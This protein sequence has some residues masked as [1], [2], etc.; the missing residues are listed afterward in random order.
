MATN[1]LGRLTLDLL[2]SMGSFEQGMNAAERKAKQSAQ[3]MTNSFKGFNDQ[4][5]QMI[6]GTQLGSVIDSISTKL[7]AMRGGI[8]VVTS[9]LAGM[10]VGGTLLAVG[11]LSVM[12]VQLAKNNIELANFAAVANTSVE[13]FQGLAGAA[14]S[15]GITQ[16]KLSDQLK[17]FNEKIGE[18][19]SVGSGGAKDFFE[20][21]AVQTE[22]GAAG[23]KKLAEEMSKKDGVDALQIYV[24]KLQEAGV[25]QQQ[26]SFYL[27]SMGSDLTV[28]APLL[29]NG[30]ALWK[31][32]QAAMEDAGIITGQEAIEKSIEL[33][34]QTE[35]VQMQF[36]ALKNQLAQA[37]M[38]AL[39]SVIGYF[40]EGSG[41]GGQFSG[42]IEGVGYAAK[43][44]AV[45]VVGLSAGVK[46][47]VQVIS[48]ALQLIGNLGQTVIEFW[49]APSFLGKGRAL[50]DGFNRNGNILVET[51]KGVKNSVVDGYKTISNVVSGQSGKFDAL[52]QS[53]INNKKAQMEWAKQ[54]GKGVVSGI[55][56]NKALNPT[57]KVPKVKSAK[58]QVDKAKREQEALERAQQSIV[59]QY[60]DD[61]L[62]LKLRYEADKEKIVEAFAKDP[63]N[64]DLYL[65]KAKQ[66]Y[67]LDVA[68]YKQAQ[69][70]KFAS[71]HNDFLSKMADAEDAISISNIAKRYGAKS[72]QHG[73]AQLN[74]SSRKSKESEL[75][76]YTN[77]VN[78]INRDYDTPDK[79]VQRYELLEQAKAAHIAKMKALDVEYHD[80]AKQLVLDNKL[81]QLNAW[82]SILDGAQ[83]TFAQ[84]TQSAKE[85]AGEQS[86]VY[87]AMFA[88]QQA[89]SIASSMVAAYS[90]YAQAFADPS[91]MT[92]PQK[93]AGGAAVMA[94]LMPAITT[95]SSISLQGMAHDGMT[96]IPKEGTWL[97]D[98]GERVLN[99]QQNKDLTRYLESGNRSNG[100]PI[101]N[102][103]TL[104]G[105][106]AS[107]TRNS[108]GSLDIRMQEIAEQVFTGQLRDPN[109]SVSKS[110]SQ[111]INAGRKRT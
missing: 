46:S 64:R 68:A 8:L 107:A 35:S 63:T 10:A 91:A 89:F 15:F 4:V 101:V 26:M 24:D 54:Q 83:N 77:D 98:G 94:A 25:N 111:N 59:M 30:G 56:Q 73:I 42:V 2:V 45:L 40:L 51:A 93:L 9:A 74:S 71:Y 14:S 78:A 84:L 1:S 86:G 81:D 100:Q 49:N 55:D 36:T 22:K 76:S 50:V 41:K 104:P 12:A 17:D 103:T 109:S 16:E 6:G 21:I 66:A 29:V 11:S 70:E 102:V 60:A 37:V 79:A 13:K 97:L 48:G 75:D 95:I 80:Q 19:A 87:R 108:D 57:A 58:S 110:M 69:R 92:L 3:N 52:T 53:I 39:S 31:D 90:A 18:F 99:P 105:T 20:Q 82:S 47:L 96:S 33:A 32:Y 38:P 106:T 28:L 62:K 65:S 5:Q 72:I 88:M 85:G 34:A 7:G 44:T 61:E 43:G 27:E 23:A 67:N